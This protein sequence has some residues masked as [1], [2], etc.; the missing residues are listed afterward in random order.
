M[1]VANLRRVTVHALRLAV[2]VD[3]ALP[4]ELHVAE[5]LPGIVDLV[6]ERSE[7]AEHW[8]LSRLDGSSLDQ[9]MTL[10]G[11][12]I[13][14]G[15]VLVLDTASDDPETGPFGPYPNDLSHYVAG[16][17]ASASDGVGWPRRLGATA[18]I[19]S[20]GL[21]AVALVWPGHSAAA[22][23][24]V[25]AAVIAVAA[26][27]GAVVIDRLCPDPPPTSALGA[28]AVVFIAVAGFLMV[29]NGPA[30]PNFLLA[31]V[32]CSAMS[33]VLLHATTRDTT[34][35]VAVAA[36][37]TMAAMT[38]AVVA[39]WPAPGAA[40]GAA[41]AAVSV[42]MLGGAAKLTILLTGLS[43]VLPSVNGTEADHGGL[44]ACFGVAR[45]ERAHRI[46]T[47]L[48][49]GFAISAS[50]GI[51]LVAS[52][53]HTGHATAGALLAGVVSATL[54]L[55][56]TQQPTASRCATILLAGLISAATTLA[57]LVSSAPQH[58]TWMSLVTVALG[59]GALLLTTT[60]LPTRLSPLARRGIEAVDRLAIAAVVPL[61]CWVGDLFGVVRGMSMS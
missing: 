55:R 33:T 44:P 25:A 23:R 43:P 4:A 50:L 31:A 36:L 57:Q 47:G 16:V 5:I 14:D 60:Q 7:T 9:A 28:M 3:L 18:F 49:A 38:A 15:D 20:A 40:V 53:R 34:F 54:V 32:A 42:A 61:A 37:S 6:G 26:A 41:L 11:N 48:M 59:A 52:D 21:G 30:P 10:H 17:T 13:R 35:F 39:V 56:A 58:A 46:L 8:T 19:W 24:A 29:P 45:A 27:V 51:V 2:A 1:T 22:L 12:G